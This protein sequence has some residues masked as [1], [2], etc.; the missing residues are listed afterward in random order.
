[1]KIFYTQLNKINQNCTEGFFKHTIYD[2]IAC[3]HEFVSFPEDADVVFFFYCYY[4]QY[5]FDEEIAKRIQSSQKPV[6]IFDFVE[7]GSPC[8]QREEYL[9]KHQILGYEYTCYVD[10]PLTSEYQKMADYFFKLQPQIKL[11]F[12]REMSVKLD[13]STS[14]FRILPIEYPIN[15]NRYDEVSREEYYKRSHSIYFNYG[16]SNTDRFRMHGKL[17]L[18]ADRIGHNIIQTEKAEEQFIKE[19]RRNNITIFHREWFDRVDFMSRNSNTLSTLD[20]YGA[21]MKCFRSTEGTINTVAFKQ[22]PSLLH[23]TY[24]WINGENCIHLP[25]DSKNMLKVNESFE[26]IHYWL[27]GSGLDKLYDIYQKSVVNNHLYQSKTYIHN[28]LL[29]NIEYL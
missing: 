27:R 25:I 29:K 9:I 5:E 20:L 26:I 11:Y 17:L 6:V 2:E 7:N 14:P 24:P 3:H 28:Y 4:H 22:D 19:G 12:K 21:G 16:L 18:E 23:Y 10:N 13:F 1:M 8:L 15:F